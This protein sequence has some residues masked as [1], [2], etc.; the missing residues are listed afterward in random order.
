MAVELRFW[1]D[2][3]NEEKREDDDDDEVGGMM[4]PVVGL[5]KRSKRQT[6]ARTRTS[7]AGEGEAVPEADVPNASVA[8]VEVKGSVHM[9]P[10]AECD[11]QQ[12]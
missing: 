8:A 7:E 2:R 9:V 1:S 11:G 5:V 12:G 10:S 4:V 6:V 3:V